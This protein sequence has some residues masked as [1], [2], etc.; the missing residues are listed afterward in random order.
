MSAWLRAIVVWLAIV[1]CGWL[2]A[3][4][5]DRWLTP[6]IGAL[7]AHQLA[8]FTACLVI[9]IVATALARW[10]GVRDAR[11]LIRI[12]LTW[13]VLTVAFEVVRGRALGLSWSEISADYD[14]ARGGLMTVTL[15]AL[16]LAPLIGARLRNM[17]AG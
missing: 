7:R 9:L 10:L 8:A 14:S 13:V 1:G 6:A 15:L 17:I 3:A 5:R 11:Q 16:T 12:G 4:L 2:H